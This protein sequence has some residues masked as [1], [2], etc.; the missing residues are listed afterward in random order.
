MFLAVAA[1][2]DPADV[3]F[4]QLVDLFRASAYICAAAVGYTKRRTWKLLL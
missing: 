2:V 4:Q 3:S 1:Q